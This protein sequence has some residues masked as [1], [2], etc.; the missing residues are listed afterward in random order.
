MSNPVTGAETHNN[1][2]AYYYMRFGGDEPRNT[3]VPLLSPFYAYLLKLSPR[4]GLVDVYPWLAEAIFHSDVVKITKK[5]KVGAAEALN[6]IAFFIDDQKDNIANV[7]AAEPSP[8]EDD[9]YIWRD[10]FARYCYELKKNGNSKRI[11]RIF[12]VDTYGRFGDTAALNDRLT[13]SI[14]LADAKKN[15][16]DDKNTPLYTRSALAGAGNPA[17][18]LQKFS[19]LGH[20]DKVPPSKKSPSSAK[21]CELGVLNCFIFNSITY[22]TRTIGFREAMQLVRAILEQGVWK[23]NPDKTDPKDN[24]GDINLLRDKDGLLFAVLH[25][26]VHSADE[27]RYAET[28]FDG[29]IA[30]DSYFEKNNR[31]IAYILQQFPPAHQGLET[32]SGANKPDY[33]NA[34]VYIPQSGRRLV[35]RDALKKKKRHTIWPD[36]RKLQHNNKSSGKS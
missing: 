19:A 15:G 7:M 14:C 23:P 36:H 3:G 16:R 11:P 18:M 4:V 35:S 2:D 1:D 29:I 27:I 33:A 34:R 24:S 8:K 25:E 26:E 20:L 12:V 10:D 9:N 5:K 13:H 30:F 6:V 31:Y 32:G 22:L 17:R 21:G 28:F